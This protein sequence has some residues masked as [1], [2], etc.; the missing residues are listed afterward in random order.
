MVFREKSVLFANR[1][2]LDRLD[3]PNIAAFAH[4]GGHGHDEMSVGMPGDAAKVDRAI[5]IV[6]RTGND[7]A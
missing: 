4:A 3:Y 5:D 7:K 2:L 1:L 6:M